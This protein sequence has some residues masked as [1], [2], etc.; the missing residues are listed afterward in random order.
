MSNKD[1][2]LFSCIFIILTL[3]GAFLSFKVFSNEPLSGVIRGMIKEK[4][5]VVQ[6]AIVK[7][8]DKPKISFDSVTVGELKKLK[9][10]QDICDSYITDK[11][12]Y[13]TL[14]PD[15]NTYNDIITRDVKNLL[16]FQQYGIKPILILEPYIK[17]DVMSWSSI[18][19][20]DYDKYIKQ[21]FGELKKLGINSSDISMIVP[22]P[23]PNVPSWGTKNS[24]PKDFGKAY[25]QITNVIRSEFPDVSMSLLFNSQSYEVSD[26]EWNNGEYKGYDDYIAE[27]P[28]GYVQSLGIQGFPW[29]SAADRRKIEIVDPREFLAP[30]IAEITLKHLKIKKVWFNTGTFYSKYNQDPDKKVIIQS[31]QRK[32]ILIDIAQVSEELANKGFDVSVNI[33]AENKAKT[34]EAT[35]WSYSTSDQK[36][37]IRDFVID[38]NSK[39]IGF[40][41]ADR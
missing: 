28:D 18:I 37:L 34:A 33:F 3:F 31:P 23:E 9:E 15:K 10:Y 16:Q 22:L 29:T 26:I 1:F 14:I 39:D 6:E 4:E 13:F 41:I 17:D 27:I 25:T 36:L 30:D 35:D 5:V 8:T 40:S 38:L 21:Y 32:K 19:N 12:M 7:C 20:G 24:N 11:V 2:T